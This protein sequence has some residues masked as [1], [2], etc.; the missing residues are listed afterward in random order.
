MGRCIDPVTKVE[1]EK[2]CEAA[3]RVP[4]VQAKSTLYADV[5]EKPAAPEAQGSVGETKRIH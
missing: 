1:A 5:P 2:G 4:R 3:T